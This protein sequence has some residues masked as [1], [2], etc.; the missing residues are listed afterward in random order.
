MTKRLQGKVSLVTGA[1]RGIRAAIAER[2]AADGAAV[3]VTDAKE[4]QAMNRQLEEQNKRIVLEAFNTLFNERDYAAASKYWSPTYIQHSAHI[5]PG[6]DGLFDLV[7]NTPPTLKY[8]PG[9]ILAEGQWVMIHGRF[10]DFGR[11]ANWIAVDVLRVC[12]GVLIEHWDV[13]QDEVPVE[14]SKSGTAMFATVL[15]I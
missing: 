8:E 11:P 1:S 9:L 5:S 15:P 7:R 6:R 3:A 10:S 4:I 13:L 2:L 14:Q 12:E